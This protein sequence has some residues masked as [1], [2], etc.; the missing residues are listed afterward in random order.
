M[1]YRNGNYSAFYVSEPFYESTLGARQARDFC[2]YSLLG[3][4]KEKD[5]GFPFIDS[6]NKTYSVRDGSDWEGTLKPRLHKRLMNSKNI[7]LFLSSITKESRALKE[8]LQYGIGT[9]HLPVIVVYPEFE[10]KTDIVDSS[11]KDFCPNI[12]TLWENLPIF[13]KLMNTVPTIHIPFKKDLIASALS[14]EKFTVQSES[15]PDAYFY[16]V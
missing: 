15:Q 14:D 5:P 8:E 6:H 16:S 9:L 4:W 2:Y 10:S 11:K 7:I 12:K 1:N 13:K 3:A